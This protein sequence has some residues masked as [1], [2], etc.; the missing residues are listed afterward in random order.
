MRVFVGK[1]DHHLT[2]QP[3]SLTYCV[4]AAASALLFQV[5]H[6]LGLFHTFEGFCSPR[7]WENEGY[8]MAGDGVADVRRVARAAHSLLL[9]CYDQCLSYLDE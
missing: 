3:C 4:A 8:A 6:W 9:A 5:G 2:I 7:N 1:H